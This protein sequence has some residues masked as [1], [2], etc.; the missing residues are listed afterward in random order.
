MTR[1]KFMAELKRLFQNS[2]EDAIR[3]LTEEVKFLKNHINRRPKPTEAE[4][5]ALA[6]AAKAVDPIY[7]EKT[8]N[9][10]TPS[11]LYRWYRELVRKKWDYSKLKKGRGR[12]RI[13]RELEDLI[14]KLA[15][16][17]PNDGYETLVGKL[18][19]L[20]FE[21]NSETI[22]NVLKRNGIPPSPERK[23]RLTWKEFLDIHWE[24][25]ISTDFLTWET[26]TPFG[27]ITHYI[28]FFIRLKDRKVHIA[29][30]TQH[31]N[32]DWMRQ[33][34][35]NLTDPEIG[36]LPKGALLLHDRDAKYTSHFCRI[37][38]DAGIETIPL[39]PKSPNLNAYAERWVRTVKDQCLKRL[40]ITSEEQLRKALKEFV[41]FYHHERGHQG[42]GNVIPFP[43]PEDKV[44][45]L[46]GRVIKR[47]RLGNLLNSYFRLKS[48]ENPMQDQSKLAI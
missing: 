33:I 34:A 32:G 42:I 10:F 15:L 13:S 4:K 18:K 44:G 1:R 36:F 35:R 8:F 38:N 20:G 3:Y 23:D 30:T 47:S 17:N 6:R 21:T 45:S 19:T 48:E 46:E 24:N 7:L 31:P 41:E 9:L 39:P 12:P 26:L 11:T 37:L 5:T 43:K 28:L 22:Q 14:V 27:L 2:Q 16:E 25:L 29:G 40:I